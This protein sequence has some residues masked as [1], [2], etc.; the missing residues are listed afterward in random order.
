MLFH[1]NF[2]GFQAEYLP[3]VVTQ[4]K[5]ERLLSDLKGSALP[6]APVTIAM[7]HWYNTW[8]VAFVAQQH[9]PNMSNS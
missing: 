2:S 4:D 5:F 3:E 9:H 8:K 7:A 6:T 1:D